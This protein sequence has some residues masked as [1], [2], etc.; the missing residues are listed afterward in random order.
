MAPGLVLSIS[1][2]GQRYLLGGCSRTPSA[3]FDTGRV[4]NPVKS[5]TGV[6]TREPHAAAVGVGD[7]DLA[8]RY[9]TA[10]DPRLND[11]QS[12]ELAFLVAEMLRTA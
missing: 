8:G 7:A 3:R 4:V 6:L 2:W 1:P 10:C 12:L 11:G 5:P 9:E